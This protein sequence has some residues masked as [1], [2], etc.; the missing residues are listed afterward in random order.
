MV[1]EIMD[2]LVKEEGEYKPKDGPEIGCLI[3]IDR[4]W[5]QDYYFTFPSQIK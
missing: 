3:V 2:D 4:G 5:F 1:M